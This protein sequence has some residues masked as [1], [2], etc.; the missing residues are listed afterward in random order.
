MKK[1]I[2]LPAFWGEFLT[3]SSGHPAPGVLVFV[4]DR[5]Q[6]SSLTPNYICSAIHTLATSHGEI[7]KVRFPL[8]EILL[9]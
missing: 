9:E 3:T 1:G 6:G 2:V 4:T 5:D 7:G 8:L